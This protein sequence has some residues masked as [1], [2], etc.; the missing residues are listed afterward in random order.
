MGKNEDEAH[1]LAETVDHDRAAYIKQYFKAEWPLREIYYLM[2]NW[3][4]GDDVVVK[5]I[6]DSV[7]E[8]SAPRGDGVRPQPWS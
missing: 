5:A 7:V 2:I 4:M 6:L 3:S 1:L 8:T